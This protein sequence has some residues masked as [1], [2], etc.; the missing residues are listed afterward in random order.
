[1]QRT[2]LTAVIAIGFALAPT[3]QAEEFSTDITVNLA[4]TLAADEDVIEDAG[5]VTTKIDVGTLP[6]AADLSGYSLATNGDVLFSL[7]ISASLPGGVAVTPRDVVRWNGSLYTI[8][9]RGADHGVP[10]GARIDAIGVLAEDGDLL[11]SFDVTVTL[12]NVTAADEDLVQL[13]STQPEDWVLF[14]DGSEEG[15]PAGADLDGADVIDSTGHLALSFDISGTVGGVAFADED[16]LE[17]APS[18]G[19]WSMRYD[20]SAAHP[21]LV[22]ADVDALFVPEPGAVV[23]AIAALFSLAL[24]RRGSTMKLLLVAT[25]GV[26]LAGSAHAS[27]GVIEINQACV[28]AGCGGGDTPGYPVDLTEA[29][30]YRLTSNLTVPAGESG[31]TVPSD[32]TLDLG[33]F[34]IVGPITCSGEPVTSC[35]AATTTVGVSA[36]QRARVMNGAI[37]GFGTGVSADED[38]RLTELMIFNNAGTGASLSRGAAVH[39]CNVSFNGGRGVAATAGGG[40]A[41]VSGST[42]RG[43][44]E[45]GVALS[46]GLVIE[47][48]LQNNGLEGLRSNSGSADAGYALN[49]INGNNGAGADVLG[50]RAIGCNVIDGAAVCP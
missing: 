18:T 47:S 7:D 28:A 40:F 48:R 14:F 21:E 9:F 13:A 49:V 15:V 46:G 35:S 20:G 42:V 38:A 6:P 16:I 33:G 5:G 1:M 32:A 24:R 30:S 8:E 3:T 27:D 22:A 34:S 37:R 11:L 25:L 26:G 44:K 23:L 41:E 17:F 12:G 2:M 45:S 10:A 29:G 50:G 4:G 36:G 43:N 39:E 31:V 19:T